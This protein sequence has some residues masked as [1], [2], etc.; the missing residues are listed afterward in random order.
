[1]YGAA[2]FH[3]AATKVHVQAHIGCE[4]TAKEGG[5]YTLLV[6]SRT[7]YQNLCR[8]ITR[9]KLRAGTK[10]PKPG[11]EAAATVEDFTEFREGLL[12]LTGGDEG[13]L[14]LGLQNKNA[15]AALERLTGIFGRDNVYVEL[16]RHYDR[17][18]EARNQASIELA[19][20]LKL[21]LV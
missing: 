13:P 7:G 5:R 20:S 6:E 1:V 2:R 12:C 8:L 16:Q 9:M 11:H 14:A 10:N 17:D 19:R 21:P 18:E 3:I 15:R 4:V